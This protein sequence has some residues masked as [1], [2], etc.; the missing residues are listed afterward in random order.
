[1]NLLNKTIAI[2][3][4]KLKSDRTSQLYAVRRDE[5]FLIIRHLGASIFFH[6]III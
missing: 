4:G 1:M 5:I 6:V 3:P 2:R